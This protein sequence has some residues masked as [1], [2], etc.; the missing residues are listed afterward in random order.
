MIPRLE[1]ICN[2]LLASGNFPAN[3]KTALITF[4]P[5]ACETSNRPVNFRPISLQEILG[6][7]VEKIIRRFCNNYEKNN[8]L[9]LKQYGF[10]ASRGTTTAIAVAYEEVALALANKNKANIIL[11]HVEKAFD[12]VLHPGLRYQLLQ[13]NLPSPI[14]KLISNFLDDRKARLILKTI[15]GNEFSVDETRDGLDAGN[16]SGL[17]SWIYF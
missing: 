8:L 16:E 7:F 12:K 3:F 17:S 9:N 11:R 15:A 10:R 1:L 13:F 6:K 5:K 14:T 4:I 2:A